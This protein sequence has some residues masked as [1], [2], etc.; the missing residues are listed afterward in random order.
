MGAAAAIPVNPYV[1]QDFYVPTYRILVRS[2]E[3]QVESD[4]I[5]LTYT[6][7]L[8]DVDS[9]TLIVNNWD[10]NAGVTPDGKAKTAAFKYSDK[11]TFNPWQETELYMG[12]YHNGKDERRRMLVGEITTM[13]PTFPASGPS[14]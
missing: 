12:Y 7:S 4:V 13:A 9:F 1:G 8:K 6:D 5:S 3:V 14:T 11:N 10:P 2:K